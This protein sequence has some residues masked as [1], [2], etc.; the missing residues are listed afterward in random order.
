MSTDLGEMD[1]A[2]FL[3]VEQTLV[4]AHSDSFRLLRDIV[5]LDGSIDFKESLLV[6]T[7]EI[8]RPLDKV[9]VGDKGARNVHQ[10]VNNFMILSFF[11]NLL[12]NFTFI[13]G[14]L[15]VVFNVFLPVVL[16]LN[17]I[18][19]AD[20]VNRNV[21]SEHVVL[22]VILLSCEDL[23]FRLVNLLGPVHVKIFKHIEKFLLVVSWLSNWGVSNLGLLV[24]RW[25]SLIGH[26]LVLSG[27]H[28]SVLKD[29]LI[30]DDHQD[31]ENK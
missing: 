6:K 27:S 1:L 30:F 5:S 28:E 20:S 13:F 10:F 23:H 3:F 21:R 26:N 7:N 22:G 25:Q 2:I 11:N 9:S 31:A 14:I 17:N 8:V 12:I 29:L 4:L 16:E 19:D 18:L 15:S 24:G